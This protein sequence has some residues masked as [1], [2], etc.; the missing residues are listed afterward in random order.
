MKPAIDSIAGFSF[1]AT[2]DPN[3]KTPHGDPYGAFASRKLSQ[4]G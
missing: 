2:T 3:A 1:S 4:A